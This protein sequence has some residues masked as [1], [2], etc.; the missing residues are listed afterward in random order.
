MDEIDKVLDETLENWKRREVRSAQFQRLFI[1]SVTSMISNARKQ[2]DREIRIQGIA[3]GIVFSCY[4]LLGL[5]AIVIIL[6]WIF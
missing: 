2:R 6:R 3:D 4:C 1:E 5:V